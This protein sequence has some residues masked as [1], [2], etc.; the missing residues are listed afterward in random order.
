M[1]SGEHTRAF[2]RNLALAESATA[3]QLWREA[4]EGWAQVTAV[5]P[6]VGYYWT[7]LGDARFEM[8]DHNGAIA[9]FEH[10]DALRAGLHGEIRLKIARAYAR[11]GDRNAALRALAQAVDRGLRSLAGVRDDE[12][13]RAFHH[14]PEFRKLAGLIDAKTMSRDEGWRFDLQFLWRELKRLAYDPFRFASEATFV[15]RIAD[16]DRRV[17]ELTD[18]QIVVEIEH[19][20]ALL[21]DGHAGI[22]PPAEAD[23]NRRALPVQFYAFEEGV[24]IIAAAAA[25]RDLLGAELLRVGERTI[26]E[27]W[28]ALTPLICRDNA[29]WLKTSIPHRLRETPIL[30]AMGLIPDPNRANLTLRDPAGTER[31]VTLETDTSY[32]RS[33]LQRHFFTPERWIRLPETLEPPVPLYERNRGANFWFEALPHERLVYAQINAIRDLPQ[34]TLPEFGDHLVGLAEEPGYDRLV[35][36]L[37]WNPGGNTL[38]EM[39][40]LH[41][42]IGSKKLNVRGRLFAII[43]RA[44][45]SAAQNFTTLLERHTNAIFVGEPTGSSPTF[46]G[47]TIEFPLPYSQCSANVSDLLWQ[48]GWPTDERPWV[49]PQFFTPPTFAAYRENRDPA[50]DAIRALGLHL[51]AAVGSPCITE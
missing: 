37:R 34:Q 38:L 15:Q 47:E 4:A 43:G 7:R 11:S 35:L 27:L 2:A 33:L 24:F 13:F 26:P 40:L 1:S 31:V 9:A 29:Q 51:P 18:L 32:H 28:D 42:L 41:R 22:H 48:S 8:G 23:E 14:D 19:L 3:Q 45:F 36:D 46:V 30:H 21:G 16:L 49:A 20:L 50:L 10:A 6:M 25:H 17:P 12:T 44:T 39:P 5:N